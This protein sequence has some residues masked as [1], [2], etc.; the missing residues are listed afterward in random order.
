MIVS[1]DEQASV[2][3]VA[4]DEDRATQSLRRRALSR[5][6]CARPDADVTVDLTRLSF[7]DASLM[8]DL[9]MVARRLR[10]A[11]RRLVLHGAQPDIQTLIELVGLHRLPG[12]CVAAP[13]V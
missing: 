3:L 1:F 8:L 6:L 4:G 12:V 7:A 13:A 10:L 5:A 11:G 2:L 9:A